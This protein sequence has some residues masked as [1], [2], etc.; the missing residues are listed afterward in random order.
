MDRK[1]WF[2]VTVSK[3]N[4][5]EDKTPYEPFEGHTL[6]ISNDGTLWISG[7]KDRVF[8]VAPAGYAGFEFKRLD[9]AKPGDQI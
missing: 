2:T 4:D 8:S 3:I 1:N 7:E 6:T 9:A 5:S